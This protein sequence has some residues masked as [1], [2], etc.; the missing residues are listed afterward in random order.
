MCLC[1]A[2]QLGCNV[3][4]SQGSN[5][6]TFNHYISNQEFGVSLYQVHLIQMVA[7]ALENLMA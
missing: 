6:Y 4:V 5:S 7:P 3:F 1:L 2:P